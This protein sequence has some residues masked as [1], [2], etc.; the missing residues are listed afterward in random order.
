MYIDLINRIKN[1]QAARRR[2]TRAPY[3]KMDAAI[4][5]L[6]VKHG[7]VDKVSVVGRGAKKI[8]K[9]S[10]PAKRTVHEFQA[11]SKPSIDRYAG[12]GDIR[13][14]KGGRGLLV[15]STPVGI[16]EGQEARKQHVGGRLL[17]KVW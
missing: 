12:V 10:L 14:V 9:I 16:L 13:A 3:T 4:I 17:F 8:L 15:L 7:F 1:A 11:L 2:I 5:M 6:L